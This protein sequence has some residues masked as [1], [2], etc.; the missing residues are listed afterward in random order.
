MPIGFMMKNALFL[1]YCLILTSGIVYFYSEVRAYFLRPDVYI[2][3]IEDLKL[4]LK[5]KDLKNKSDL[6]QFLEFKQYVATVL[7]EAI[8]AKP[9]EKNYPLRSL[10]SVVQKSTSTSLLEMRALKSFE[11]GKEQ[12]RD[13]KYREAAR[14]FQLLVRQHPY[15]AHLPDA[16][17]FLVEAH[18]Q[19]EEYDQVITNV[20]KMVDLYPE[21][22]LTGYAL[23]RAAK[24]FEL[25]ERHDEAVVFYETVIKTFPQREIASTAESALRAIEL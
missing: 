14:T 13:K 6:H 22:E 17:F 18:F 5:E 19:L 23:L 8:K 2:T 21:L 12:F 15:S 7:P 9:Q 3:Q 20:N 16:Y 10:A 25:Q 1:S 4:Q 11:Q 24:V